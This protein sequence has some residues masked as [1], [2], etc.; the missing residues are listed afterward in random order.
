MTFWLFSNPY[1]EYVV[2]LS[3]SKKSLIYIDL[4]ISSGWIRLG[5]CTVYGFDLLF[6]QYINQRVFEKC[7]GEFGLLV[8]FPQSFF[9][10]KWLRMY[11]LPLIIMEVKNGSHKYYSCNF[12]IEQFFASVIMGGRVVLNHLGS[13]DLGCFSGRV[14]TYKCGKCR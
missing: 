8:S 4:A 7:S 10:E 6:R 3:W 13:L 12:Q 11:T 14:C 5:T 2:K 9:F 1:Q